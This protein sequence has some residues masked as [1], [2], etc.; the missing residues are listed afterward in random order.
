MITEATFF[1]RPDF[2][3][4]PNQQCHSIDYKDVNEAHSNAEFSQILLLTVF[5]RLKT[6]FLNK[7]WKILPVVVSLVKNRWNK[8]NIYLAS[9]IWIRNIHSQLYQVNSVVDKCFC[10][11]F[12]INSLKYKKIN[13]RHVQI[14][15]LHINRHL[16]QRELKKNTF[17]T[18]CSPSICQLK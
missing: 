9:R 5:I 12:L 7:S 1:N 17:V 15:Y 11:C 3:L 13:E 8:L 2:F 18:T 6:E 14:K 10:Y 16:Q 4:W